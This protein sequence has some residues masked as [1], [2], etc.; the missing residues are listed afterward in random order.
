MLD[1]MSLNIITTS[2]TIVAAIACIRFSFAFLIGSSAINQMMNKFK[3]LGNYIYLLW[4]NN[5]LLIDF[6]FIS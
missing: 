1:N 5:I 6:G 3:S 2:R 4:L